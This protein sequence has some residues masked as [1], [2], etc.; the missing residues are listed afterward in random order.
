LTR[1]YLLEVG[2]DEIPARY[3]PGCRNGL[4]DDRAAEALHEARLRFD[5]I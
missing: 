1:D 5:A 4:E 2:S 3:L